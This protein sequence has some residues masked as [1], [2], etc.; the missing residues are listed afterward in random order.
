MSFYFFEK[1]LLF[2]HT[3]FGMWQG[4]VCTLFYISLCLSRANFASNLQKSFKIYSPP[5]W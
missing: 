2:T 1:Q 3:A 5:G 4:D